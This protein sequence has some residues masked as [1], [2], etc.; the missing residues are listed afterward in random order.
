VGV[1]RGKEKYTPLDIQP[2]T[3][4]KLKV[5][6]HGAYFKGNNLSVLPSGEQKFGGVPFV[7]GAGLIQLGSTELKDRPLRVEG[8]EV[9]RPFRRLHVLHANGWQAPDG[10][11]IG[12]YTVHYADKSKATID[13][14]YGK[15]VRDWWNSE[16]AKEPS[17]ARLAWEGRNEA[18]KGLTKPGCKVRLFL[19]TWTNPHPK[20]KVTRIDFAATGTTKAA[21]F[22]VAMTVEQK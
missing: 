17:D 9:G 3:N 15:N 10:T 12:S 1:S 11:V 21:P 8:I 5:D 22:C 7:I 13:I 6:F 14:V 4:H 18:V 19:M 20:K 2:K 16:D